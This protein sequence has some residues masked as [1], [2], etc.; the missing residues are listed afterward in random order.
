M[1]SLDPLDLTH[2]QLREK[3]TQH[4]I[5]ATFLCP[6]EHRAD[7]LRI[8]LVRLLRVA[9]LG[10]PLPEDA[11]LLHARQLFNT[12]TDTEK[13]LALDDERTES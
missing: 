10:R 8:A 1:S 7:A 6:T 2:E 11:A 12:L 3:A 13:H 4:A 9:N 5:E